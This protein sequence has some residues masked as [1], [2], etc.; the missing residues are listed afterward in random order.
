M[1]RNFW[2]IFSLTEGNEMSHFFWVASSPT[3]LVMIVLSLIKSDFYF[4]SLW[5]SLFF[6]L[7][8]IFAFFE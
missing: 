2:N 8:F 4:L 6:L 3:R 7:Q 5:I 1:W